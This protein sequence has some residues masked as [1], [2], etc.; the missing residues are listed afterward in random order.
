MGPEEKHVFIS[1]V[2]E[3]SDQV[4]RLCNVLKAAGIP[5]W[6]DRSSLGPGDAWKAKIGDAI[7]SGAMVF[8]AC[9]SDQS[10]AKN[11]SYMNEELTL[12]AEE[13]RMRSPGRTWLI[14]IRFDAGDVPDWE[15]GAG[16]TL[17]DLNYADLFG[18]GHIEHAVQLVAAIKA[19]MGSPGLEPA[20]MRAA[21][22]GP[23]T[24]TGRRCCAA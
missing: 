8:L 3:D 24:Q 23:P 11:R 2:R 9:F 21:S 22:R 1:Y 5:Y 19:A 7:R 16:R 17:R 15:L 10:R 13:Y 14:P 18:D 4:D 12:A 6:R 20:T